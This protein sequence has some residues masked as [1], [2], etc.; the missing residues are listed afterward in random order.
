MGDTHTS[1]Q[2]IASFRANAD[3]LSLEALAFL[4]PLSADY[5]NLT[6]WYSEKVWPGIKEGTRF[7]LRVERQSQL[8]GVGI[9]KRTDDERKICTVRIAPAFEGRGMGLRIFDGLMT[10][11]D[12]DQP[13]LTVSDAKL[14]KFERIFDWYGFAQTSACV[15]RYREGS[16]EFGFN[17]SDHQLP[18][19]RS[20]ITDGFSA[21]PTISGTWAASAN[22]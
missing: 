17:D 3:Q 7:I 16:V 2:Q 19:N 8:V 15:G 11:L 18:N 13:H 9:A 20:V 5:P 1:R 10:W 12:T 6:R 14:P 22:L 4:A 21:T